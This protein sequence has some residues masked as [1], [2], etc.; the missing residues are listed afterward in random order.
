MANCPACRRYF[1]K[2]DDC[3]EHI[4]KYHS[5]D[6]E[7][8]GFDAAQWLYY[9][10]HG[11]I[12]GTCMCGCG[13][14]TEWNY[15]TGKPYKVSSDPKCRERLS[16]RADTNMKRI[17]GKT[18]LLDDMEHQKEMQKHRPTAGK[19]KF[20]DGGEV[21]FL[22]KPEE[23]FLK[24]CDTIMEMSSNMIQDSPE[25][26]TYFD[27]KDQRNRQYI[28]DFYLPDYNLLIEIKDGGDHPNTNP[29]FIK[30]TK[31]KVALKDEVMKKQTK[32]NFIKI[33]D[34]NFG[35]FVELLYQ[36]V[37]V[38]GPEKDKTPGKNMVIITENAC[39]DLDEEVDLVHETSNFEACF[40]ILG[41]VKSTE[42]VKFVGIS[43]SG[44]YARSYLSD[45][46][47]M[48]IK[49]VPGDDPIF[50]D[51]TLLSYRYIGE[52]DKIIPAM[53]R[54]IDISGSNDTNQPW[55]I[56]SIF[57]EFGINFTGLGKIT[58]NAAKMSDFVLDHIY[59]GGDTSAD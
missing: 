35:P 27:T 49:E 46:I 25:S 43:E 40:L 30:E 55:D 10:T 50:N 21:P 17:Y 59:D 20:A 42:M 12:N 33:V 16:K 47:N 41:V 54:I 45:M 24:F 13:K 14:P 38:K 56:L 15:H 58:N 44:M 53:Q 36:I 29:A 34:N 52:M 31:Y 23:A 2:K 22:S 39:R 18:T 51:L 3:I 19:Y 1:R 57:A 8:L 32:Y 37:H 4:N 9:S 26:F 48:V 6:M 7:K 5:T 11:T 28:P